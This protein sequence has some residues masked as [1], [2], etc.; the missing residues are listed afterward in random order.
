MA[1]I[2]ITHDLGV[3][4]R[5]VNRVVVMY[6]GY[7]VE[8]ASVKDT[9]GNPRHPYTISLLRSLPRIDMQREERLENIEGRPPD[10]FEEP[11]FC[12][13]APRCPFVQDKCWQE[14]PG[15]RSVGENHEIAC[16]FD[17]TKDDL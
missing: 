3:V 13:F 10:L 1:I 8:R 9:Y 6:A 12:P 7:P 14:N 16:W 2:W 17:V 4:A 5:L 11:A 15:M